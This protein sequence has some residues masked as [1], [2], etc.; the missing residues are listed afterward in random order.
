V[1]IT[2][3]QKTSGFT[4]RGTYVLLCSSTC[5]FIKVCLDVSVSWNY[6]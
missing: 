3:N 2:N 5:W 4:P 1:E 6:R